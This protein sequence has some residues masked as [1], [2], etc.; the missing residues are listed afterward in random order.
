M[1]KEKSKEV[2]ATTLMMCFPKWVVGSQMFTLLCFII[3]IYPTNILLYISYYKINKKTKW[4]KKNKCWSMYTDHQVYTDHQYIQIT[5]CIQ[6]NHLC[7]KG[8]EQIIFAVCIRYS[9]VCINMSL[10]WTAAQNSYSRSCLLLCIYGYANMC[11]LSTIGQSAS[12]M[13]GVP[14]K[15]RHMYSLRSF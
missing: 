5:K 9:N 10:S 2:E 8:K 12:G 14:H 4:G 7:T 6:I 1:K 3:F 13:G 11:Y 15:I